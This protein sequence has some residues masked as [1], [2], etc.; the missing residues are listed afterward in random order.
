[1]QQ[2]NLRKLLPPN[3]SVLFVPVVVFLF[4]I[5]L[6]V[7]VLNKGYFQINTEIENL[8]TSQNKEKSLKDKLDKL[9]DVSPGTLDASNSVVVAL[10]DKNSGLLLISQVRLFSNKNSLVLKKV[11]LNQASEVSEGLSKMELSGEFEI[12]DYPSLVSLLKDM[13]SSA[14]IS[15]IDKL[16]VKL[17]KEN[18]FEAE[19]DF[20]SYWGD[21]PK[22]LPD[23][24]EPFQ[25]LTSEEEDLLN[26]ITK[27]NRPEFT[28][29]PPTSPGQR[30]NPFN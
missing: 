28:I 24:T 4:V 2:I 14:P 25:K 29:L 27:L 21:L 6:F 1:M 3:I 23:I 8:K 16:N 10:P 19:V 15:S 11:E 17:S 22:Q 13:K 26:K 5:T 30:E 12:S 20:S 7:M 9:K 18:I